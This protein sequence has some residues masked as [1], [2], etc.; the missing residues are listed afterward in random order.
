MT[1]WNPKLWLCLARY[2]LALTAAACSTSHINKMA[3]SDYLRSRLVR[4]SLDVSELLSSPY[5][6]VSI[7][8][9]D[10]NMYNFCL[11]LCPNSGPFK[12]LRLHFDV[13]LPES[14]SPSIFFPGINLRMV[15]CALIQWPAQPPRVRSSADIDHPNVRILELP[16]TDIYSCL[17]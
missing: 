2:D 14:V 7:H 6:G 1:R 13:Q 5:D 17:C 9:D 11:H 4:R 15:F 12:G 3:S 8:L 10:S 16:I